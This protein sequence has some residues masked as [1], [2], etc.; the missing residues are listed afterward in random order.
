MLQ[1]VTKSRRKRARRWSL[2]PPAS[3]FQT[4]DG[5]DDSHHTNP[6]ERG[7]LPS[8]QMYGP[9]AIQGAFV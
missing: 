9:Q 6:S 2:R 3:L 8:A 7:V 5:W 1:P 4:A